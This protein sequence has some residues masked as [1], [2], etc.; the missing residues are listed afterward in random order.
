[1]RRTRD[2]VDN[3]GSAPA[4]RLAALAF[5]ELPRVAERAR[6]LLAANLDL[7]RTFVETHSQLEVTEAPQSSVMF[8]RLRGVDDSQPFIARLLAKHGVAVAPGYFFEAPAHFR[9]SL[10]GDTRKLSAGLDALGAELRKY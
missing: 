6:R 8:P 4:D 1:M 2:V 3:A 10:A 5:S 7:A 9:V